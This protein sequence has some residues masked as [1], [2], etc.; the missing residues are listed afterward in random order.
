VDLRTFERTYII[1]V[2]FFAA[3]RSV[4]P[5]TARRSVEPPTAVR[6]FHGVLAGPASSANNT[7]HR[8]IGRPASSPMGEA[9][10]LNASDDVLEAPATLLRTQPLLHR[11]QEPREAFRPPVAV[12]EVFDQRA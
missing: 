6:G 2:G 9:S 5:L 4:P 3:G 1:P 12:G 8:Q 7:Q 11:V 10:S